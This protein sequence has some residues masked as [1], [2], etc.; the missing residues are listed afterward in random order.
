MRVRLVFPWL[1]SVFLVAGCGRAAPT[2]NST[3]PPVPT[4]SLPVSV[5]QNIQAPD[6]EITAQAFLD[7]WKA[8]DY[9]AMYALLTP[10][11]RDAISEE[12]FTTR[13]QEVVVEAA[14]SGIDAHILSSLTE[15]SSAQVFYR[16]ILHSVLVG[17]IQR[18]TTMDLGLEGGQWR[19]SWD[20]AMVLPELSGGN[21]FRMEYKVP[22]RANIYDREG[23]ALVAQAD[24]VALGLL[25]TE[26]DPE[27]EEDLLEQLWQ[28]TGIHPEVLKAKLDHYRENDWYMAVGDISASELAPTAD[29]LS[30][31]DGV[32]MEPFRG[33]YYF[34]GGIAPHIIGYVSAIQED[35]IEQYKRLGYNVSSDRVGRMGLEQW[36]EEYLSGKRGG[37]LYVVDP[38]G[39]TVTK[40]PEESNPEPAQ[41]I[42]TTLDRNLQIEAQKALGDFPGAIVVLERDTGRVLAMASSPGFNPNLFEPTNRNR[43]DQI[44]S[45]FDPVTTPWLNRATQGSYPLGSVFKIITM[46]AALERGAYT[47]ESQYQCGYFFEEIPGFRSHDWTYSYFLEDGRTPPS[48]LLTLSE[49]LMRSC[50]P[51]FQHIG[52]DFYTREMTTA[53]S[54]MARSF[55]LGSPTGIE[56]VEESGNIPEPENNIDA[57]NLAIGQGN[58]LVT[59]LQVADFIAAV[60]NGGTLYEPKVVEKAVPVS[61]EPTHIFTPSVRGE[62]PVSESM[63][64]SVQD[65]M[66][67]VVNNPRGT[68]YFVLSGFSNSYNIPIAGKTGTAESGYGDPHAWFAGYT[69]ANRENKPDIAVVVL[70]ENIGEGSV[71]A[72]PIFRRVLE[73]Y[74]LGK[75]QVKFPWEIEIGVVATPE[76]QDEASED[77]TPEP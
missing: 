38:E 54:D 33:R 59:P 32:V 1:L 48:G 75:P 15:A 43:A 37:T 36:G 40:L 65:A 12:N 49:G 46:S 55:G 42:Y 72:A 20:D 34:D 22:S 71:Y 76:A 6:A 3:A 57:V 52:L 39:N 17:D 5:E 30:A 53:I 27:Q 61:G 56:I 70:V 44:D 35:E 16:I 68:A 29:A 14:L 2:V 63:L 77:A 67:S 13:Y 62:L 69:A 21:H 66:V 26:V 45:I 4:P 51:Y 28:A 7:A 60:G 19:I 31:F 64:Q 9:A 8:E 47:P 24:A 23:K 73:T 18:D 58:T 10:L 25:A 11:S 50:N 74:F 41:A